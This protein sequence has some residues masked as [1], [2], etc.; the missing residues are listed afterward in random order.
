MAKLA[1]FERAVDHLSAGD[2]ARLR[3]WLD[4]YGER[5]LDERGE[6]AARPGR[7]GD[8]AKLAADALAD[9]RAG[10]SRQL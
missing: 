1:D 7:T 9:H 8:L 5:L 4:E 2:L 10:R 6:H 3:D